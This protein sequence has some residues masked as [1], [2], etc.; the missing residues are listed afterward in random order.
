MENSQRLQMAL[1]LSGPNPSSTKDN[2]YVSETPNANGLLDEVGQARVA[3]SKNISEY[4]A[5]RSSGL[6]AELV[7][8]KGC[9][10]V[11]L[12]AKTNTYIRTPSR[13]KAPVFLISGRPKDVAEAKRE[14]LA[15]AEN[16][17]QLRTGLPPSEYTTQSVTVPSSD[18]VA[19]IIGRKGWRIKP[20]QAKARI[21]TPARG[22]PPIFIITGR[23]EDVG[24]VKRELITIASRITES[25]AF[26]KKKAM[27]FQSQS[28][29]KERI[30]IDV[31]VPRRAVGLVIGRKGAMIK[32]IQELT[33]TLIVTPAKH[34][35]KHCFIVSGKPEDV[36]RARRKIDCC[37]AMRREGSALDSHSDSED[38]SPRSDTTQS[39]TTRPYVGIA[40]GGSRN[41]PPLEN[42]PLATTLTGNWE[43]GTQ[44]AGQEAPPKQEPP[45]ST[46]EAAA[47][48]S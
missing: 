9:K 45:N 22:E 20:L 24:E 44:E 11:A 6:V 48:S 31:R 1:E 12:R 7:G 16:I 17:T 38:N 28:P 3:R 5:V 19:K 32:N 42:P 27:T 30:R 23:P 29:T 34:H 2:L 13:G 14:L 10:M 8:R 15:D 39:N 33:N 25:I 47:S 26:R 37:V 4:V 40:E 41:G 21:R 46:E 18:H 35:K 43:G 36:E